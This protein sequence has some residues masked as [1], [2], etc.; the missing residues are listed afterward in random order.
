MCNN[1]TTLVTNANTIREREGGGVTCGTCALLMWDGRVSYVMVT[2][3]DIS[4]LRTSCRNVSLSVNRHYAPHTAQM[5]SV[6]FAVKGHSCQHTK[7]QLSSN[8]RVRA[9]TKATESMAKLRQRRRQSLALRIISSP[10]L[11]L[12]F[13]ATV[14]LFRRHI[15][16]QGSLLCV[17]VCF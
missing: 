12:L 2:N 5:F 14:R 16:A 7:G 1:D 3:F 10:L 8:K 11:F 4:Y 6:C 9:I 13:R 15:S 17:S